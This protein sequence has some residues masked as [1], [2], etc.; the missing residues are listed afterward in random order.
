[1]IEWVTGIVG[2]VVIY[3][4]NHKSDSNENDENEF[5]D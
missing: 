2:L 5:D 3:K 1:M 4:R